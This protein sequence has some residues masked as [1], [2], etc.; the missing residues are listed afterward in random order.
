LQPYHNPQWKPVT[1][2]VQVHLVFYWSKDESLWP[3]KAKESEICLV[4]NMRWEVYVVGGFCCWVNIMYYLRG[5][6]QWVGKIR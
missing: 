4:G 1:A 6:L 3:C 5:R 2:T